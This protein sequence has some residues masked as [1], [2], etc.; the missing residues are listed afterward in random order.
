[1]LK[2]SIKALSTQ[3]KIDCHQV[4]LDNSVWS[5]KLK[6]KPLK[7]LRGNSYKCALIDMV[8]GWLTERRIITCCHLNHHPGL[9]HGHVIESGNSLH[10]YFCRASP[11]LHKSPPEDIKGLSS[12]GAYT[13]NQKFPLP[14]SHLLKLQRS[15][16]YLWFHIL[17]WFYCCQVTNL[18]IKLQE[19]VK[20][21]IVPW[22]CLQKA[23]N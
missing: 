2:M 22:L 12:K 18:H 13:E 1:M 10:K 8:R 11:S 7:V 15:Y 4:I 3:S 23:G 14:S 16:K 17:C 19:W 21:M 6:K 20:R 9:V 5:S